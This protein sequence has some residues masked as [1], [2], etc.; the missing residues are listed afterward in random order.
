LY[1][2]IAVMGTVIL[3][4]A[5]GSVG[6]STTE[7]FLKE[8]P[9]RTLVL[10]VR[11]TSDSDPHTA[12][13]RQI[14]SRCPDAKASIHSLDLASLTDVQTFTA[15]IS[16]Q[17]T[18]GELPKLTSIICSAFC[19][20]LVKEAELTPDSLERTI[21]VNHISHVALVLRLLGHFAPEGGRI[22]LFSSSVHIPG[23]SPMEKYP[24][25]IPADLDELVQPKNDADYQ[26]RGFQ[27]YAISKLVVTMWLYALNRYLEKV[28]SSV[29]LFSFDGKQ[30]IIISSL[31]F[32]K[33][34]KISS[35]PQNQHHHSCGH[36]S[37][38]PD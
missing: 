30:D 28:S 24:P 11:N 2:S 12:R 26:G 17:I 38:K 36:Q 20:N 1:F 31:G 29:F 6:I 14:I 23:A 37:W 8:F 5:N 7:H 35:G 9:N 15:G 4:G 34:L 3:T 18:K 22:V 27:R 16:S 25:E 21:Q 13:L 19:W 10:T 33:Q 32:D